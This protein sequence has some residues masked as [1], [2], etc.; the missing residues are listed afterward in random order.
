M[1]YLTQKGY[2]Q[3]KGVSRKTVWKWLR[4]GKIFLTEE[5]KID[6]KAADKMLA[7]T[8]VPS[9]EGPS[10]SRKEQLSLTMSRT[11]REHFTAKLAKLNYEKERAKLIDREQVRADSA[12]TARAV[13]KIIMEI[14]GRLAKPIALEQNQDKVFEM[15]TTEFN[16][17]LNAMT[18]ESEGKEHDEREALSH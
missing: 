17:V 4:S 6:V 3:H 15:L 13:I 11:Q 16:S 2:A 5:R 12:Q 7:Q 8:H 1:R 10:V 9:M 14:P 18:Q